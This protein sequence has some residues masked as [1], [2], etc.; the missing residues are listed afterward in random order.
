MPQTILMNIGMNDPLSDVIRKSN[1][2]FKR[3]SANT[4]K[5]IT[6]LEDANVGTMKE[7]TDAAIGEIEAAISNAEQELDSALEAAMEQVNAKVEMALPPVNSYL[8]A[9][10]NP[11]SH[12]KGTTWTKQGEFTSGTIQSNLWKRTS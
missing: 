2:N 9:D 7:I 12:Y 8:I 4:E 3:L 10:A 1:D 5:L 6:R 11:T